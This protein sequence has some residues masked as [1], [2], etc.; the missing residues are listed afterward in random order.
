MIVIHRT[1]GGITAR[2]R[3]L[4]VFKVAYIL[5]VFVPENISYEGDA[6][7]RLSS[8][9]LASRTTNDGKTVSGLF[10]GRFAT[11]QNEKKYTCIYRYIHMYKNNLRQQDLPLQLSARSTVDIQNY[12]RLRTTTGRIISA[13]ALFRTW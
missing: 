4:A 8:K 12:A 13:P 2:R 7:N 9:T 3:Q 6:G 5:G 1:N 11:R 10:F